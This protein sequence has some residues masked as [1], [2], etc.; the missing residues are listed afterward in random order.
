VISIVTKWWIVPGKESQAKMALEEL[1]KAVREGE[2]KTLMY[3]LHTATVEGS[4]PPPPPNEVIF[5]GAWTDR[6][7]FDEHRTG[8][9]FSGWLKNNLHLFQ[10]NDGRLYVNAEFAQRF[11]G[12]VRAAAAGAS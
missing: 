5:L 10:Q 7:A 4:K 3:C 8:S 11:A 6:A 2:P 9:I 12:F 1:A